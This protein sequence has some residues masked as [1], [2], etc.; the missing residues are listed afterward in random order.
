MADKG[1]KPDFVVRAK[2]DPDGER[3]VTIGAAWKFKDGDGYALRIN[4]MPVRSDGTCILVP[5]LEKE[6]KE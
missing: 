1:R 4:M 3:W 5:P 2:E 6:D